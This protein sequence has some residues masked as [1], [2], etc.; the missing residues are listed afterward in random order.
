MIA[1]SPSESTPVSRVDPQTDTP[2]GDPPNASL[3]LLTYDLNEVEEQAVPSTQEEA[4]T[5]EVNNNAHIPDVPP[6]PIYPSF[7]PDSLPDVGNLLELRDLADT[8]KSKT[9]PDWLPDELLNDL[10]KWFPATHDSSYDAS[11]DRVYNSAA[12]QAKVGAFFVPRRVFASYAQFCAAGK[13]LLKAWAVEPT[14]AAKSLN[15]FYSQPYKRQSTSQG[16][17]IP[18]ASSPKE[19]LCPFR[20]RY[21]FV[22]SNAIRLAKNE[23]PNILKP[24]R[25]TQ[26]CLDHSCELGVRSARFAKSKS[27]M[28]VPSAEGFN[29]FVL[30][31]RQ[32][33]HMDA[34][35]VR[36]ALSM[37]YPHYVSI[38]PQMAS[39]L[40]R[41]A[42]QVI[43]QGIDTRDIDPI[44][45]LRPSN[46]GP[47]A[48]NSY[49]LEDTATTRHNFGTLLEGC[50][51]NSDS[52][53][54][55]LAFLQNCKVK[56]PGF[57]FDLQKEPDGRPIFI[58]WM[59]PENRVNLLRFGDIMFLDMRMSTVNKMGFPYYAL[60]MIDQNRRP[61]VGLECLV[62][63]ESLDNYRRGLFSAQRLEPRW[64]ISGLRIMCADQ[65]MQQSLLHDVGIGESC[66]LRGDP[67]HLNGA[68]NA[69]FKNTFGPKYFPLITGN[70]S[71]M[72]QSSEKDQW[73]R[74]Y[75]HAR[76]VLQ[77]DPEK[78]SALDKIYEKPAYYAGYHIASIPGNFGIIGSTPAEQNHASIQASFNGT[79]I[80]E[81]HDQM[82]MHFERQQK[83][84]RERHSLSDAWTV[85]QV[86]QLKNSSEPHKTIE[87]DGRAVLDRL[88]FKEYLLKQI[89]KS[90]FLTKVETEN[91]HTIFPNDRSRE[92]AKSEGKAFTIEAGGRCGCLWRNSYLAQCSHELYVDRQF[93]ASKWN[94]RHYNNKYYRANIVMAPTDTN[95]PPGD[96]DEA[97]DNQV[98][99]RQVPVV[100]YCNSLSECS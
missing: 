16:V 20:I 84:I 21:T 33:P 28:N 31:M 42:I 6:D 22:H 85:R 82:K 37:A 36:A 74:N 38:S 89:A 60:T 76:L 51:Q 59:F 86:I 52:T 61:T 91:G 17:R 90:R 13:V 30:Q 34:N 43:A 18:T 55:A 4:A 58:S 54:R 29:F 98:D 62:C 10:E 81:F 64:K 44:A 27:K 39:N 24:V 53:W 69:V 14:H 99:F 92:E 87:T 67:H 46:I 50:L 57:D 26:M 96:T 97:T 95:N 65:F 35:Q 100:S 75:R 19:V 9:D 93:H 32:R 73:E 77:N 40:R 15:C 12:F 23:Y 5:V 25:I 80:M 72:L 49:N 70:L 78:V 83:I 56:L 8:F 7:Y 45:F 71:K 2:G 79:T 66:L 11:G 3:D 41:K 68:A 47:V 94:Q 48:A 63:R 88:P 1:S